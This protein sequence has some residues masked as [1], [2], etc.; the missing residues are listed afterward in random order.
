M[1]FEG[2]VLQEPHPSGLQPP[3]FPG[4]RAATATRGLLY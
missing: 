1:L 2:A 4:P 3:I